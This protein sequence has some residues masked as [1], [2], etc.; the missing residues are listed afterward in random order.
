MGIRLHPWV[1]ARAAGSKPKHG[2][3]RRN[4]AGCAEGA[5][6]GNLRKSASRALRANSQSRTSVTTTTTKIHNRFHHT[7][8]PIFE[9]LILPS[10][11]PRVP[12]MKPPTAAKKPVFSVIFTN[13]IAKVSNPCKCLYPYKP[14][15]IVE[16]RD[17]RKSRTTAYLPS[18]PCSLFRPFLF[19]HPFSNEH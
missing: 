3:A 2:S 16:K 14:Y 6:A 13:S 17:K 15:I 11:N 5:S 7:I 10:K 8:N 1:S 19:Y 4:S 9:S 18:H 12:L